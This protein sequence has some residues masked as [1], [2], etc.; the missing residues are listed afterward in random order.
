MNNHA[1]IDSSIGKKV[2]EFLSELTELSVRH[3]I[4]IIGQPVLFLMERDDY[5]RTYKADSDS[6]VIFD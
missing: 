2:D 4:G 3:G 6:R 5:D 1:E